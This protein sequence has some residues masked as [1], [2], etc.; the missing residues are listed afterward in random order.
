MSASSNATA[1]ASA[2][3]R[4]SS[5]PVEHDD[6]VAAIEQRVDE[7]RA[8]EAGAARDQCSHAAGS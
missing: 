4:F 7:I 2:A 5:L 3:C 6:V 1:R 8:D